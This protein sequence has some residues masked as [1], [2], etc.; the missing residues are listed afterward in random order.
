MDAA[1]FERLLRVNTLGSANV[2]RALLPG[3]KAAGG[4]QILFT[5]SMAG[6]VCFLSSASVRRE[7]RFVYWSAVGAGKHAKCASMWGPA[8][9]TYGVAQSIQRDCDGD[10]LSEEAGCAQLVKAA[11]ALGTPLVPY[12]AIAFYPLCVSKILRACL[13][14]GNYRLRCIQPNP[15]LFCAHGRVCVFAPAAQ[16][17]SY[18]YAAYSASKFALVG[19]AQSL[20]MEVGGSMG[21]S[22]GAY[23]SGCTS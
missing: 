8:V 6:Q 14:L 22:Y 7:S 13:T 16:S 17:G 11:S 23:S 1:D 3:M 18:G 5:S 10:L 21:Q 20:Q 15:S 9:H 2:T 4:G 19:L 12:R